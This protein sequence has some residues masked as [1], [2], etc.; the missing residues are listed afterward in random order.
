MQIKFLDRI[1]G[2]TGILLLKKVEKG[3]CLCP[4]RRKI[5]HGFIS[6]LVFRMSLEEAEELGFM[7]WRI[8]RLG[9]E[10]V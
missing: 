9:S 10:Q 5:N 8:L 6:Y 1:T 7:N 2:F 3:L 4:E